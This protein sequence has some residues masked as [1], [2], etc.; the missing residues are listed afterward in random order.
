VRAGDRARVDALLAG[1][2][3]RPAG[4]WAG[5]E[6]HAF[7]CP[8]LPTCGLALAE[9]E[10]ALPGVLAELGSELA[11]LGLSDLDAHVRMTGCPNGCARPYTAEIGFVGRGKHRYDIHLGGEPV[12]RRL[13][14]R[15]AE[16]VPR[17]ELVN[18][19]RPVL[20][21]YRDTRAGAERF[22]DWCDRVGVEPLRLRL[23]DE[24]WVR[25]PRAAAGKV[26]V[27]LSEGSD[28]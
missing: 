13:N 1:H 9:S 5:L 2:G 8:A 12:G 18:V 22:G 23:G 28:R 7:A 10:R 16:N 17:A 20:V 25:R 24:R 6:R 27:A 4:E 3:V 11:V 15:F 14:V 26:T 21:D 19:L